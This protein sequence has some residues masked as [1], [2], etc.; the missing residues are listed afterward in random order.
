MFSL[1]KRLLSFVNCHKKTFLTLMIGVL[2]SAQPASSQNLI[3]YT[4]RVTL[5]SGDTV[6]TLHVLPRDKKVKLKT[7]QYYYW[8]RAQSLRCTRGG[9]DGQLLDGAYME[10]YP[11]KNIKIKGE[12]KKGLKNNT[13]TTWNPKGEYI[14]ITTWKNGVKNGTFKEYDNEGILLRSGVYSNDLLDGDITEYARDGKSATKRYNNGKV[15]QK[16]EKKQADTTIAKPGLDRDST[17][18]H[19]NKERALS[20]QQ[21]KHATDS[22]IAKPGR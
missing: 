3:A 1:H 18:T 13:W 22:T 4:N 21:K 11:D 17:V 12:F 10:V 19:H 2:A 14:N 16:P 6:I 7:D 15:F 5:Q 8:Y 20:K 9:Y